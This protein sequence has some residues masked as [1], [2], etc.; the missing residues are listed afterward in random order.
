MLQAIDC[1]PILVR[2]PLK[3]LALLR[4]EPTTV[5]PAHA[6][7]RTTQSRFEV[8]QASRFSRRQAAA[9]HPLSDALFLPMLALIDRLR[10]DRQ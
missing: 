7:F 6:R 4:T 5:P 8:L 9:P 2:H 3:P 1:S 10:I